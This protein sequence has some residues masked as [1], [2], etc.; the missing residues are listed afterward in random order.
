MELL[1]LKLKI[2]IK[3]IAHQPKTA[4]FKCTVVP[5]R[6][7]E[8]LT[9]YQQPFIQPQEGISINSTVLVIIEIKY[10]YLM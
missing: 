8:I 1:T 5:A 3:C 7:I 10:L 2:A 4:A 9:P 6:N